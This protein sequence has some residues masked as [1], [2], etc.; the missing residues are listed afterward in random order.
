MQLLV[1]NDQAGEWTSTYTPMQL[2]SMVTPRCVMT[3][4]VRWGTGEGRG[5]RREGEMGGGGA[6]TMC[7]GTQGHTRQCRKHL[8]RCVSVISIKLL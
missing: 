6:T 8:W 3:V 2:V 5:V 1:P 7:Q 4:Q